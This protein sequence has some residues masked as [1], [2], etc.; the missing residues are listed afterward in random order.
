MLTCGTCRTKFALDD[1]LN[2]VCHKVIG[3]RDVI[4]CGDVT[5]HRDVTE[6]RRDDGVEIEGDD[7]AAGGDCA[8]QEMSR[9]RP[10]PHRPGDWIDKSK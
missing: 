5:R 9:S 1:I 4:E 2:F 8:V 3:C 10:R 7:N 6:C